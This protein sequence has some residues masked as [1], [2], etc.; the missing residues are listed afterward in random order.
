MNVRVEVV[1]VNADGDEQRPEVVT[2]D[3]QELA[4]ELLG[5]N[6]KEGKGG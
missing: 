3:R 6:L 2:I 4:M 1:C 5:L